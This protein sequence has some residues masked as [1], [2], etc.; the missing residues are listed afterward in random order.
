MNLKKLKYC[1]L[2]CVA[3]G[4]FLLPAC[5]DDFMQQDPKVELAEGSFLKNEGDLPYYLNQL[6]NLYII[7]HGTAWSDNTRQPLNVQGSPIIYN[8][9][10]TDNLVL[11]GNASGRL[12]ETF[13]T[14]SSGGGW[15]WTSLRLVNYFLRNYQLAAGSVS[16]P[17][18]LNKWAAEAYFF[19]AW[20]YYQKVLLFGEV[21]WYTFD[22]NT[23]SPELY[24]PRTSRAVLMDSVLWSINY[25]VEHIQDNANPIGRINRDMANFLKARITL[26]EGTF[27]KYQTNLGLQ[28]TANKWLEECVAACEAI[29]ATNRYQL[30]SAGTDPYWRLFT[31]KETPAA[32]GNTEAILARIYDGQRQ[33]H[34]TYRYRDQNATRYS[35]GA[36]RGLIDEYLC[37]DGRPI[38]IG[39]TE[40]NYVENP[41]FEGYDGLWTE[42]N[43][44]DPRLRQSI[45]RPGEFTT[46]AAVGSGV[47]D[48]AVT[49]IIYPQIANTARPTTVTGYQVCKHW[50]ND[51]AE[52]DA[53]TNGRQTAVEFRL[54][55]L[56]LMLAEAK[57]ELGT[58]TDEDLDRTVNALRKRAGYNF[59]TY[60]DARLSLQ[61][62]PSDPRLDKIYAEKLDYSVSPI[63][64]EIRRERRV[65]LFMEGRRYED[66]I[67]WKAGKLMTV[68]LRGMKFTE[69]K[70][71]L[72]NGTNTGK[73]ITAATAR[74]GTEVWADS[75]GFLIAYP[76][77]SRVIQG[78]LPWSDF[79]YFHP[80]NL[81]QLT[82]NRNL[83]QANGWDDIE[84]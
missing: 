72:Y 64:R 55:E 44:R 21:P 18:L 38:Y 36:T 47:M 39:G 14:P 46:I 37:E 4:L 66:L 82:I 27:R 56:L 70:Q 22:L 41:H 49:G 42:L 71:K 25:A 7:G 79:R 80:I 76:N 57:A 77:D 73:P 10:I 50:M 84:R 6:Y 78:V 16:N 31:F 48:Q 26:F 17:A 9:V 53:V 45:A 15:D 5:N 61:N 28:G 8:D 30:Y 67:R 54:G 74:L 24:A 81:E 43:N 58:I 33:G 59:V 13:R 40:G 83:T 62:I 51:K 12:N 2:I 23:E 69:E 20:D 35:L 19:K 3:S 52:Y 65:E 34:A 60:P 68:P 63:L 32:D 75:E 1:I 29:L 11:H